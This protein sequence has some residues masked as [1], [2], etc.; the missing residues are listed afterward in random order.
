[1]C[2]IHVAFTFR[3]QVHTLLRQD[4]IL[5]AATVC[6]QCLELHHNLLQVPCHVT[7]LD[8]QN[9]CFGIC[10]DL[11]LLKGH[12]HASLANADMEYVV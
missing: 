2:I 4:H 10:M 1:M 6:K 9:V 8:V 12:V 5:F 11:H 3:V 7:V